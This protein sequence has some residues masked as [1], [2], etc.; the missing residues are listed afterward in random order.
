MV[1][2][3]S[4]NCCVTLYIVTIKKDLNQHLKYSCHPLSAKELSAKE[5]FGPWR[6]RG[7]DNGRKKRECRRPFSLCP[8]A[9]ARLVVSLPPPP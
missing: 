9:S 1:K 5:I 8:F 4:R 3:L 2:H 6:Y 7:R